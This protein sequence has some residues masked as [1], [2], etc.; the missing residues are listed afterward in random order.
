MVTAREQKI[1][2]ILIPSRSADNTQDTSKGIKILKVLKTKYG[3][4]M[5]VTTDHHK[6][7]K[8]KTMKSVITWK[9]K[10]STALK[11]KGRIHTDLEQN[12]KKVANPNHNH[13]VTE[14]E[15]EV[16]EFK[17]NIKKDAKENPL[18]KPQN[19][20]ANNLAKISRGRQNG[21]W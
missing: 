21:A 13:L 20:L 4:P 11:C 18:E 3:G 9:C 5:I 7:Y 19:I 1:Y 15:T 6:Y 10:E 8:D 14:Q 17:N 12:F 2:G 16:Q